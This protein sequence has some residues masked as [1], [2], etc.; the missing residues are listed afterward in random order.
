[1]S[2]MSS[3]YEYEDIDV[4]M[5]INTGCCWQKLKSSN[6]LKLQSHSQIENWKEVDF[7]CRI[8]S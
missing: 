6:I 5:T 2:S 1:M 4:D 8:R 7:D 3:I